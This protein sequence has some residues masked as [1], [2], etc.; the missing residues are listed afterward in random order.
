M[1]DPPSAPRPRLRPSEACAIGVFL[2]ANILVPLILGDVFPFTTAP[3]FRDA[4]QTYSVYRVFDPAGRELPAKDLKLQRIYDG[5]PP[6]Y[7]VGIQPPHTLCV[8]GANA[9]DEEIRLH[10]AANYPSDGPEYLDIEHDIIGAVDANRC[11][12]VRTD[13]QRVFRPE[14]AR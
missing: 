11:G 2:A 5:N 14:S 3:M 10:V 12:V 6:G 1:T 8:F 4:P 9:T 7:G 13:K